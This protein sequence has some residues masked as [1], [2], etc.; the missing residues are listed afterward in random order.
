MDDAVLQTATDGS[1]IGLKGMMTGML[2]DIASNTFLTTELP[3]LVI[4]LFLLYY[5][6][7]ALRLEIPIRWLRGLG[8][9]H[10]LD[11]LV[12][13]RLANIADQYRATIS[14]ETPDGK[15]TNYPASEYFSSDSVS[16]AYFINLRTLSSAPGTL[17][18]LGLLGTFFGLMVGINGFKGGSSQELMDSINRLLPGMWMAFTTSVFG[19][20]SSILFTIYYKWTLNRLRRQ[21]L[22]VNE[23]LD[24]ANYIDDT[25]LL[26]G[27]VRKQL[28]SI[29]ASLVYVTD[30]G[31]SVPLGQ[32]AGMIGKRL[33]GISDSLVYVTDD[34]TSVPVGQAVRE[35]LA[36]SQ[37]QTKALK[38][39]ST[40][41][42]E[43]LQNVMDEVMGKQMEEK[44]M[45]ALQ[46]IADNIDD[47]GR[48]VQ[49][50]ASE[51]V[52]NVVD[53]LEKW[54]TDAVDNFNNG[55]SG[56]A[57]TELENLASQLGT[58][59]K[60]LADVPKDMADI[61]KTLRDSTEDVR[62]AITDMSNA[63][64]DANADAMK[65]M[66]EQ[67]DHATASINNGVD[68]V[69]G[70]MDQITAASKNSA[71]D[72]ATKMTDAMNRMTNTLD[73]VTGNVADAVRSK[74]ETMSGDLAKKQA[75]MQKAAQDAVAQISNT[76][77]KA[78]DAAVNSINQAVSAIQGAM[79]RTQQL[80]DGFN[81]SISNLD[82]TN[83]HVSG[84]MDQFKKAQG[85]IN[86]TTANLQAVTGDMKT[87]SGEL[88]DS[89]SSY[90]EGMDKLQR[91]TR[92]TVA[93]AE[94]LMN[95]SSRMSQDYVNKFDVIKSELSSIFEQLQ[96]GMSE[97]SRT[98]QNTTQ[99]YLDQY[100]RSLNDTVKSLN[101]AI[102][103]EN[104]VVENLLD[105]LGKNR[106]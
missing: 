43:E 61:S 100:T 21:L 77:T 44:L 9:E 69:K 94:S 105:F 75:D 83:E 89:L 46:K 4:C 66:Q 15:K 58:A 50:P 101:S 19:M 48:K 84:T 36:N 32:L 98:V 22:R 29:S 91:N 64:S 54:M 73:T 10:L 57:K 68:S 90:S 99:G 85:E 79:D 96:R 102:E 5:L 41:L 33:D 30:D 25:A 13:T 38:S 35:I 97:Y 37:E 86:G 16:W 28:D 42:A 92:T 45:P 31:Q 80:L 26:A 51:M 71:Q 59:T 56:S 14:I 1:S 11:K 78:N 60:A 23:A 18:G 74:L 47:V 65:K 53:K 104:E 76:S 103:Q 63:S 7:E 95:Q 52:G 20:V 8:R 12:G 39:F 34:G 40:D 93:S 2:N 82:S 67:I 87:V 17:V 24:E 55:L 81:L 72:I 88:R 3:L 62:K 49:S 70:V 106:R 27:M 6:E